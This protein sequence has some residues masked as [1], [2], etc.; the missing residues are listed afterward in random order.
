[1]NA[2]PP[3]A[4]PGDLH[5]PSDPPS[6]PL[7]HHLLDEPGTDVA[8]RWRAEG[9]GDDLEVGAGGDI[10]CGCHRTH[11]PEEFTVVHQYRYEGT[12]NPGDEQISIAAEGPCGRRGTMTLAYGPYA[13]ADEAEAARR[14]APPTD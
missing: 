2:D 13:S 8:D 10:A 5:G 12:T 11:A 7:T 3:D 6:E 1:M 4:G 14:L 9:F